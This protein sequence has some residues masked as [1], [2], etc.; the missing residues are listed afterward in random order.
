MVN[1]L[2]T[3]K[4]PLPLVIVYCITTALLVAAKNRFAQWGIDT[5]VVIVGNMILFAVSLGSLLLYQRAMTHP[6]TIGFL[7]N[8]Y[9]GMFL[10]LLACMLAVML[11]VFIAREQ[12]NKHGIYACILLY[13]IYALLEMRSLMQWNKARR[14]A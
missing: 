4:Y 9:S 3:N 14:N 8:T 5:K 10:K 6:T 11:Y 2:K 13:F 1:N 12:V 7:K